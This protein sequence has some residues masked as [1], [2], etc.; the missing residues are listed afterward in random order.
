LLLEVVDIYG[1]LDGESWSKAQGEKDIPPPPE[2]DDYYNNLLKELDI[3]DLD[4]DLDI[5]IEGNFQ[6]PQPSQKKTLNIL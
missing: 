4:L 1:N 5:N 2:D 3:T 6:L